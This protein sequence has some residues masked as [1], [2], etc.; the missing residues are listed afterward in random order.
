MSVWELFDMAL[1]SVTQKRNRIERARDN[2][3]FEGTKA[4]N[5]A[6]ILTQLDVLLEEIENM[7]NCLK[8]LRDSSLAVGKEAIRIAGTRWIIQKEGDDTLVLK[9]LDPALAIKISPEKIEISSSHKEESGLKT[10]FTN[11]EFST[12]K[13]KVKVEAKYNEYEKIQDESYYIR[14]AFKDLARMVERRS[15]DLIQYLKIK[16]VHC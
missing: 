13:N 4:I 15:G 14:Y 16:G 7:L 12:Q 6:N 8:E 11:T 9:R 1:N 10:I 5:V 3:P 2:I